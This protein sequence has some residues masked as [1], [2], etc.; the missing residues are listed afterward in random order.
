VAL[1]AWVYKSH[2]RD[3]S[4]YN[5]TIY[6]DF[7]GLSMPVPKEYHN[8]LTVLYGDYMTPVMAASK[9]GETIISPEIP[10]DQMIKK[11]RRESIFKF[12]L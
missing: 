10:S 3:A 1:A 8:L 5:E 4:F 11:L 7:E 12:G 6:L 9:H 2:K